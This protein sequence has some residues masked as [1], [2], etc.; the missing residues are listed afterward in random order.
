MPERCYL[1]GEANCK[2]LH[3]KFASDHALDGTDH[4]DVNDDIDV[5]PITW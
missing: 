5:I 2:I 1:Y 3:Y 4:D